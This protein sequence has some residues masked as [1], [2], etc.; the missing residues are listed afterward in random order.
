MGFRRVGMSSDHMIQRLEFGNPKPSGHLH[1]EKNDKDA[2]RDGEGG[3]DL[4]LLPWQMQAG[5]RIPISAR[6]DL[7]Y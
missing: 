6:P 4:F 7:S 1:E 5:N 2:E 3:D